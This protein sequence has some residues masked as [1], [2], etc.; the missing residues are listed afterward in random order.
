MNDSDYLK[1]SRL[2]GYDPSFMLGVEKVGM[3]V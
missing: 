2:Y 3:Q 1:H